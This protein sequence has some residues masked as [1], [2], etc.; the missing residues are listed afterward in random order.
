MT[1]IPSTS[2]IV[3]S[4]ASLAA[5]MNTGLLTDQSNLASLEEQIST[6]DAIS[7]PSDDP[8]GAA[9]MLQLQA[10]V[11]RANQ[12]AAN[13]Q[14]GT[15]WLTLANSTVSSIMDNLQQVSSLV[16]GISGSSLTSD[17]TTMSSAASQVSAALNEITNLANTTYEGGQPLFAGT[18]NASQAYDA[19]GNYVGGGSAPTRTVA[20]ST[21]VPVSVTGPTIFGSGTTGLLGN[22]QG[23]VP[24]T[25]TTTPTGVLQQIVNDL[26]STNGGSPSH[27]SSDLSSLQSAMSTVEAA[28]G[29]LGAAQQE[30]EGFST[31][32]TDSATALTQELGS[33]QDTNMAQ[34]VTSLQLQ[35]TAYQE[36]LYATSQ[37][38]TDSLAQYL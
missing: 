33:V 31:Q 21:Q 18:G 10:G 35:Q 16:T 12:Y 15:G 28:A 11:T 5:M 23:T 38:S 24:G 27:L 3:T 37:L 22:G 2:P 30:M 34:A 8:A 7:A 36:A 4:P 1:M 17:P 20:P 25:T 26:T 32:A 29:T 13:A 6:G 14:D 19:N 9:S